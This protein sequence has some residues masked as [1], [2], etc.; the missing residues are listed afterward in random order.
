MAANPAAPG[1]FKNVVSQLSA[2][3]CIRSCLEHFVLDDRPTE[4]CYP[5]KTAPDFSSFILTSFTPTSVRDLCRIVAVAAD[6]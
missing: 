1:A 3:L 2:G 5:L 4:S 6:G